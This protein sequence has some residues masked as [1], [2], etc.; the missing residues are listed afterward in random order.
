MNKKNKTNLAKELEITRVTLDRKLEKLGKKGVKVDKT[1]YNQ[2][3]K[4]LKKGR[5]TEGVVK[6]AEEVFEIVEFV[7]LSIKSGMSYKDG[8]SNEHKQ[9]NDL[10]DMYE[11]NYAMITMLK[12]EAANG[13]NEKRSMYFY[14]DRIFYH[15]KQVCKIIETMSR[16]NLPKPK[17]KTNAELIAEL[18]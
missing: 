2:L 6:A 17:A 1:N 12:R 3:L 5:N 18:M 14:A 10:I 11:Y 15:E 9:Y 4:E 16:I 13:G 8:D 7:D